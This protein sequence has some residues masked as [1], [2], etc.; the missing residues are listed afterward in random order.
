[1]KRY[2]I[3]IGFFS[4]FSYAFIL[5]N[6]FEVVKVNA[7]GYSWKSVS[8]ENTY[9]SAP[10]VVCTYHLPS[11]SASDAVVRIN[12]LTASGFSVK[13]QKPIDSSSVTASDVQ[14]IVAKEGAHTF[15]NGYNFEAR[16][17]LSTDTSGDAADGWNG[18]GENVAGLIGN[19][20]TNPAVLGQVM[21]YNDPD[22]SVFWTYDCSNKAN[23][24]TSNNIC[25]G[26]HIG[27]T[28]SITDPRAT[29][30]LGY[31]V[32]EGDT[33]G[34]GSAD[35]AGSMTSGGFP[36][37]IIRYRVELGADSIDGVDNA[38]AS[39]ALD[40]NYDLGVATLNAMDGGDGGWA[41][42][43][44]NDPF[45]NKNLDLAI[46]E[47]TLRN[48]ERGHTAEQVAYW[49]FTEDPGLSWMEV[50]HINSVGSG[51]ITLNFN[52][53]YTSPVPVCT[54]NLPS[55]TNNEAVVRLRNVGS[56][57]MQVRIQQPANS[58]SVTASDVHC[59]IMEEGTHTFDGRDVEAHTVAS[60]ETNRN[61]DWSNAR[62]ENVGYSNSYSM[63]VV[64][65]QV[66]SYNDPNFSVFW[67]S[68]GISK[69]NPPSHSRLYV[70][71]H[72]GEDPA[73]SV[74]ARLNE[75]LGFIVGAADNGLVNHVYYALARGGNTVKG[76]GDSPPYSYTFSSLS[77]TTYSYGV[78]TQNAENGGNGGWA[79]LYGS[80]PINTQ[81]NLAIE[82]ETAAG[83]TTRTHTNE[84]VAYWVF[85]PYPNVSL[86]KKSCVLRDGV[87]SGANAKR[88]PGAT[89]R[90]AFEV[91]NHGN[92]DASNVIV[93]DDLN[94]NFDHNTIRNLQIQ[95]GTCDCL[96]VASASNNG[97]N[98]TANGVNPVKLDFGTVASGSTG[99]PT[100]ECGYFEVDIK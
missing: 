54:Y 96:G 33:N 17:V 82:E 29:E 95:S 2:L 14:C 7:V 97:T 73:S 79:V 39:Y 43:Y 12:N 71:K 98:G 78:A 89:I 10:I 64:L 3:L 13:I 55:N 20:G 67:T 27:E 81:I 24:P 69:D 56:S 58:S 23:P 19:H 6:D 52:N 77:H 50:K 62:M 37:K 47:D 92:R 48:T 35:P 94:T 70:G 28:G 91:S 59:I 45:G 68:D 76:V 11:G 57:S 34:D 51:W 21:S 32:I 22:F 83:D 8:F 44:G 31:I 65:G 84:Q 90:Y 15:P 53:N 93:D 87:S 41:V 4:T 40:R 60:D 85:D 5:T 30:T 49:V 16:K 80:T 46:D 36:P 100:V 42:L 26:K 63:P 86:V 38:G 99:T 88:I 9:S 18:T 74:K 25:V 66:M 72:I 75:T 61:G 1:M